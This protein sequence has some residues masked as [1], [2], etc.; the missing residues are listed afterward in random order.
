MLLCRWM[1]A[2]LYLREVDILRFEVGIVAYLIM[3]QAL[4]QVVLGPPIPSAVFA[5]IHLHMHPLP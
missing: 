3:P 2:D 5:Y 4:L 1:A